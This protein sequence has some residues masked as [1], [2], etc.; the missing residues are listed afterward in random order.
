MRATLA[1]GA[2]LSKRKGA[3]RVALVVLGGWLLTLVCFEVA[4]DWQDRIFRKQLELN[5]ENRVSAIQR[6]IDHNVLALELVVRW[7][8]CRGVPPT[9]EWLLTFCPH[10]SP[11]AVFKDVC[12]SAD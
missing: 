9:S 2:G 5:A 8:N 4:R 1:G 7:L 10:I 11:P 12:N 3:F 6:E